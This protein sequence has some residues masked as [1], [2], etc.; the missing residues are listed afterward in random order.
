MPLEDGFCFS[1]E[2]SRS[3]EQKLTMKAISTKGKNKKALRYVIILL[4]YSDATYS[5]LQDSSLRC[6]TDFYFK[7]T[8]MVSATFSFF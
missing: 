4:A 2:F 6:A 1:D 3:C 7:F 8:I 5:M